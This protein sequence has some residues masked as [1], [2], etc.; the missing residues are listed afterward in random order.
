MTYRESVHKDR[1]SEEELDNV[2]YWCPITIDNTEDAY[3]VFC[4]MIKPRRVSKLIEEKT[5]LR[6]DRIGDVEIY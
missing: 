1:F 5:K 6:I 3:R 2:C 4:S